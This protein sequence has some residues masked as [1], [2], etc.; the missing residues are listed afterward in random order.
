MVS[1]V[2]Y[3]YELH[4]IITHSIKFKYHKIFIGKCT[5]IFN[6]IFISYC[7]IFRGRESILVGLGRPEVK[8]VKQALVD[9]R[10]P[11]GLPKK[12]PCVE[13]GSSTPC[14]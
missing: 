9:D 5:N 12:P 4:E 6:Y 14:G 11:N 3:P 2:H 7:G 1:M 13:T 10:S 8:P